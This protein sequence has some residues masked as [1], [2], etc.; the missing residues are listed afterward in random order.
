MSTLLFTAYLAGSWHGCVCD[1]ILDKHQIVAVSTPLATCG[2]EE[3]AFAT[4]ICNLFIHHLP[5]TARIQVLHPG[6]AYL[7]PTIE[8]PVSIV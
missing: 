6:L 5:N 3:L 1:C 4:R 8:C 7:R 2:R